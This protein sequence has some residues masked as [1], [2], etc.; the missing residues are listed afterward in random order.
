MS[1]DDGSLGQRK[2]RTDPARRGDNRLP[3]ALVSVYDRLRTHVRE[4][5][6]RHIEQQAALYDA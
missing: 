6:S 3:T 4:W 2:D 5:P 1:F